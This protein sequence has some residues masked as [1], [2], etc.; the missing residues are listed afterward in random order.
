MR[1]FDHAS[2]SP[3]LVLAP[4]LRPDHFSMDPN[5]P[6]F[7]APFGIDTNPSPA[8]TSW[9][10]INTPSSA[11][12]SAAG[13][14]RSRDE[15]AIDLEEEYFP[16]QQPVVP[17]NEE[18]WEYGEGMTIIKP[19]GSGY[20]IS[21]GSQ[22][23]T[24]AEEKAEEEKAKAAAAQ[25]PEKPIIR[26]AK[27]QRLDFSSTPIIAEEV[28]SNG[29]LVTPVA[30]SPTNG[31]LEPTV[32]D[33][34]RHLGIGWSLISVDEDIQAAARGWT[35]YIN[36][37][38]PVT[39]ASIR[40]QS[41]GLASYLV[42]AN[43]GYFLFGEDL[44]Q[45]R[46]VSRTLEQTFV[47]LQGPVPTFEGQDVLNAAVTPKADGGTTPVANGHVDGSVMSGL[48]GAVNT[49]VVNGQTMEVEM[50]MS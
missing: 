19:S 43:E 50:D 31:H 35:R 33:F 11:P 44:K 5:R 6:T 17:D 49:E 15:A 37:H 46:L 23:G 34:T 48:D 30:A 14:K 10:N 47:N 24:W 42:Q 32:D 25:L 27:S 16:V 38:F 9:S 7:N 22:T 45:G 13:R 28:M 41:K 2:G 26:S 1:S 29:T 21:A 36:N 12:P 3:I 18:E 4:Q 39:D 8:P 40:L 20:V